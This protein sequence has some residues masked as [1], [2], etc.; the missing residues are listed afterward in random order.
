[1]DTTG[2]LD[3]RNAELWNSLIGLQ[4]IEIVREKRSDYLASS[5]EGRS[6]IH[7]NIDNICPA[8][9]AHELLHIQLK[10][11]KVFIGSGLT[12]YLKG[13]PR[14]NRMFPDA[15]LDHIGNCLEHVKILP[16]YLRLGYD[17]KDFISDYS[18]NKLTDAELMEL[19]VYYKSNRTYHIKAIS[20]FI[21]KY[22]A[23][24]ACPNDTHDY[25]NRLEE[26]RKVDRKLYSVLDNLMN[27]WLKLNI[28]IEEDYHPILD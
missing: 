13:I 7:V 11:K 14:L 2:L 23:A 28:E 16:D 15:L 25:A 20:Q 1:M 26:L 3:S 4:Q 24:K 19:K 18:E 27:A 5:K 6:V 17:V 8:S 21:G 22:F 10:V 9:F 12:N